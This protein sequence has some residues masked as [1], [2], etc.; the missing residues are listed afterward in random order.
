MAFKMRS[1]P[2]ARNYGAPFETGEPSTSDTAQ[3]LSNL[4]NYEALAAEKAKRDADKQ[5]TVS[6]ESVENKDEWGYEDAEFK[7]AESRADEMQA[8]NQAQSSAG[9]V[10]ETS[11]KEA[12][13]AR[14]EEGR[15][16][17]AAEMQALKDE[18]AR[19]NALSKKERR[20]EDRK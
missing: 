13:K 14:F 16:T 19:R 2:M 1:S 17:R 5:F 8:A 18:V 3:L 4:E 15:A 9:F 20:Q 6:K 7:A 11:K 10:A 12:Q